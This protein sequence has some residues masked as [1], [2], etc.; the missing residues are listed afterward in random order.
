MLRRVRQRLTYGNVVSS[1]ALFIALGGTSYA[2][3][4]PR[5]SVGSQQIRAGA[6]RAS[7][8]RS[9][10]VRSSEVKDR[11]LGVRDLSVAARGSLRGQTG[12]PG[13]PGPA[14]PPG[15]SGVT[16][17]AAVNSGGDTFRVNGGG[18]TTTRGINEYLVAFERSVDAC[19]STATL[20]RV[21][22]GGTETP[23]AGSI[24][25]ARENGAVLVRT[26][27]AA[28]SPNQLGF[29]LIVAC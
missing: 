3:T 18:T 28:G 6:V 20:A 10:A 11:S 21:E 16:Y 25:V 24:T 1:M 15:P 27:D 13:T 14:G 22:G 4:L 29:H 2:L 5:N 8:V 7:E 26:F 19:V 17:R 12:V 23:P 9:G